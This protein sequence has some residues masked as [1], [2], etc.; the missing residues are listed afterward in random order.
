MRD[1][2]ACTASIIVTFASQS[3]LATFRGKLHAFLGNQPPPS[4][5]FTPGHISEFSLNREQSPRIFPFIPVIRGQTPALL[6]FRSSCLFRAW[7]TALPRQTWDIE[8]RWCSLYFMC[9]VDFA[10][11]KFLAKFIYCCLILPYSW[12]FSR[13][14][15]QCWS[16]YDWANHCDLVFSSLIPGFSRP[17]GNCIV[18]IIGFA[19]FSV[20]HYTRVEIPISLRVL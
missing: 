4:G 10:W 3:S 2:C 5:N 7:S 8:S 1:E 11:A 14:G 16:V 12:Y 13:A 9:F 17:F 18:S 20:Y 15:K 6:K 19:L